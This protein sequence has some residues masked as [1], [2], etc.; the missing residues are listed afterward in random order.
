MSNQRTSSSNFALIPPAGN[1]NR[2][3]QFQKSFCTVYQREGLWKVDKSKQ[4]PVHALDQAFESL[5]CKNQSQPPAPQSQSAPVAPNL[6]EKFNSSLS[7]QLRLMF[8]QEVKRKCAKR[9]FEA[10]R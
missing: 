3:L 7:E 5:D 2:I 4:E 6:E 10:T 1:P 9:S 8:A